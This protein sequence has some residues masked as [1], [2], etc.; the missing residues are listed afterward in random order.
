[1]KISIIALSVLF[2]C[3]SCTASGVKVNPNRIN[4][5]TVGKS[6][7]DDVLASLGPPT[8]RYTKP[9]DDMTRWLYTYAGV[10]ARPENFIP[11]VNAFAGGVDVESS[12]VGFRF[13]KDCIL[14]KTIYSTSGMGGGRNLESVNQERKPVR[15]VK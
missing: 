15:E 2:V 9:D 6:T 5:F 8:Q 3:S 12:V 14:E 1:M 7:C 10:Q 4:D 13:T 11:V